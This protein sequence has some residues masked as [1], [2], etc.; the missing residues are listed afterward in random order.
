MRARQGTHDDLVLDGYRE[1]DKSAYG[2]RTIEQANSLRD[3]TEH[4]LNQKQGTSDYELR[5]ESRSDGLFDLLVF[6]RVN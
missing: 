3:L 4:M 2:L 1:T 5:V 6:Q